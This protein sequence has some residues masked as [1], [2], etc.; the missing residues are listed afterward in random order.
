V[1]YFKILI[2]T[3]TSKNITRMNKSAKA[4][5]LLEVLIAMAIFSTAAIGLI[6]NITKYQESQLTASQRTIGHLVAMNKLA[7]TRLEKKWP[8]VGVTRGSEE[9]ANKTWYWLQTV[10]KTTEQNLR[11]V[12][13]EVRLEP[14]DELKVT[15]FIGFIANK[16]IGKSKR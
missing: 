8:S 14:E 4:F 6:S 2:E 9:M 3:M 12:E 16:R 1:I 7:E 13:I 15:S 11:R 5:T 10:S